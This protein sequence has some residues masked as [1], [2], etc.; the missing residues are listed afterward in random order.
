[1]KPLL[2][3]VLPR[4]THPTRDGLA[5]RNFHLLRALTGSFR[6]RAFVLRAPHLAGAAE[7][8]EG[9]EVE[10]FP[11]LSRLVRKSGAAAASLLFGGA[12]SPRLYGSAKLE[13]RLSREAVRERPSWIVAHS[14]HVGPLAVGRGRPS[15]VDFHNLDSLIWERMSETASRLPV[16]AFAA[17]Q[18]P[19]VRAFE[20]RLLMSADGASCVSAPDASELLRLAAAS[21][22]VVIPNAVDLTRYEFHPARPE[23]G[24]ILFVGD[25]SWPPN[26]EGLRWFAER[27]WPLVRAAAPEARVEVLGRGAPA[28]LVR[29]APPSPAWKFLGEGGDTRPHW[30]RADVAIV[31]LRA[32]G[33]TRLKILEAAACGVPVVST[34]V[35]SEGLELEDGREILLRDEPPDFADAVVRLLRDASLRE[36]L[37]AAARARVERR[38]DWRRIGEAFAGELLRRGRA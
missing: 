21:S 13:A 36:S 30:S 18:A 3:S 12:Y 31:P 25:L 15:W 17:L 24:V 26:A 33:G 28:S 20:R 22:P 9:I 1:M 6:I 38:Y 7:Y 8:P 37:V 11:Q 23:K 14:Y 5:I 32:G 16:R 2:F 35:G 4:P 10:E 27:V 19:R 29:R 34:T